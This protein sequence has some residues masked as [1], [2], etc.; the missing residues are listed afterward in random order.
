MCI[1][2]RA[3]KGYVE[4]VKELDDRFPD[5]DK[6]VTEQEKKDF[7]KLFGEYLRVEN[8]L[9]NYD[10]FTALK[11]FQ[12]LDVNKSEAIETFKDEYFVSDEDIAEMQKMEIPSS[13]YKRQQ[14]DISYIRA[15]FLVMW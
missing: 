1:R 3:K 11:A 14:K 9:Q 8:I 15:S 5:V 10:E 12:T 13:V 7:V 4:I 6:I 2:D